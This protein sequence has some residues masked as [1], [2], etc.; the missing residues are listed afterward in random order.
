MSEAGPLP[1][2]E[3]LGFELDRD[4]TVTVHVRQPG[5]MFGLTLQQALRRIEEFKEVD[6]ARILRA[7]P[8]FYDIPA[9]GQVCSACGLRHQPCANA[10]AKPARRGKR[11]SQTNK[12]SA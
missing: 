11:S 1:Q 7:L 4:G 10:N 8:H 9:C 2:L 12:E 3:Q 5:Q 6:R